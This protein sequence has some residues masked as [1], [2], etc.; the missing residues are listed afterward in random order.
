MLGICAV[1]KEKSAVSSA[2]LVRGFLFNLPGP[3]KP[4]PPHVDVPLPPT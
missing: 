1:P 2:E 3:A 4:D